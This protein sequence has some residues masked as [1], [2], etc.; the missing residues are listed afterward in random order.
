MRSAVRL[1]RRQ[2]HLRTRRGW[3]RAANHGLA[4]AQLSLGVLCENGVGVRQDFANAVSWYRMAAGQGPAARTR[5]AARAR[6]KSSFVVVMAGT[7]A[8]IARATARLSPRVPT[9]A[10]RARSRPREHADHGVRGRVGNRP[11]YAQCRAVPAP[12]P[13]AL[14]SLLVEAFRASGLDY[15]QATLSTLSVEVRNRLVATGRFLSVISSSVLRFP[16]KHPDIKALSVEFPLPPVPVGIVTLK[17]RT[18]NPVA[19]LFLDMA[20]EFAT[21]LGKRK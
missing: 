7:S 2:A 19:Q 8:Q 20:R 16:A 15:P 21:P 17:S 10:V 9:L 12:G 3:D 4:A 13:P 14:G 18:L 1:L 5:N 11:G 6:V